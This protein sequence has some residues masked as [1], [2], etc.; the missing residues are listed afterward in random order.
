MYK[1]LPRILLLVMWSASVVVLNGVPTVTQAASTRPTCTLT[2]T[3][4]GATA[5]VRSGA[6]IVVRAGAPFILSWKSQN[7]SKAVDRNGKGIALNGSTTTVATKNT[8][9]SLKFMEG[10]YQSACTLSVSLVSGTITSPTAAS[11]SKPVVIVGRARGLTSVTVSV[12]PFGTTSATSSKTVSVRHGTWSYAVP[13]KLGHGLYQI[14]VT[15]TKG[16]MVT[17][18]ATGTLNI[19]NVPVVPTSAPTT[20]VVVPVPLLIGGIA[21]PG[22]TL[23]VG[24]LQLI[25]IGLATTTITNVTLTQSG[26]APV[27]SIVGLTTISDNGVAKGSVGSML[28]ATPFIGNTATVPLGLVLAPKE[29]RLV[30]IKAITTS[31]ITPYLGTK[32]MLLV[33]GVGTTAQVQSKLP[34]FGTIWTF[35][36]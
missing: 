5:T 30:T 8:S 7:A 29:M 16:G 35:G 4:D 33:S 1:L 19:G 25:N 18:V 27:V 11:S 32:L 3:S 31:N 24:Y 13:Q 23:A 21:H 14:L 20:V 36:Y 12:T 22:A 15:T 34:L 2:V 10:S 26:N 28:S 6:K 17:G 9:Y